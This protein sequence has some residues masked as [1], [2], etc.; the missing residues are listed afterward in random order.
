[1]HDA[2]NVPGIQL[3]LRHV[4][5][6]PAAARRIHHAVCTVR[7]ETDDPAATAD[8]DADAGTGTD[9]EVWPEAGAEAEAEAWAWSRGEP[10]AVHLRRYGALDCDG[11]GNVREHEGDDIG[12]PRSAGAVHVWRWR[13]QWQWQWQKHQ[14]QQ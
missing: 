3:L 9:A 2:W 12:D 14:H 7:F 5:C 1:M 10:L 13:G 11:Y 6:V 8:A 4:L